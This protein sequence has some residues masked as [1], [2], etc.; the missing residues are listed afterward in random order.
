MG[1][2]RS[3]ERP[4]IVVTLLPATLE[5]GVT[6]ERTGCPSRCMVQAPH[7]DMPHPNLVPSIPRVSRKTHSKGIAGGT[8]TVSAFPFNV[9]LTAAIPGPPK[10]VSIGR[11]YRVRSS[12]P[13]RRFCSGNEPDGD[14]IESSPDTAR[15]HIA[16]ASRIMRLLSVYDIVLLTK[17]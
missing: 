9:N 8:S 12:L 2:L 6:Q 11:V 3:A 4:S 7:R 17:Q 10:M 14:V 13:R 1:L 16:G 15:R 5:I